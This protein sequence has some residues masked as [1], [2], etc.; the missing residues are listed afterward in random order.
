MSQIKGCPLLREQLTF[1]LF[2]FLSRISGKHR[3]NKKQQKQKKAGIVL[4]A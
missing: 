4:Y 3:Q 1:G 2:S